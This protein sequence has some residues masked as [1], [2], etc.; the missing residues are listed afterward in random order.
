MIFEKK[1]DY[2]ITLCICT[3]NRNKGLLTL[4]NSVKKQTIFKLVP[5]SYVKTVI[6]D[7]Y[8]GSSKKIVDSNSFELNIVWNH[9]PRKGL[10]YARNKSVSLAKNTDYCFFVDDDQK[11]DSECLV[12][13]L[14]TAKQKNADLV[15]GSNPP[16]FEKEISESKVSYFTP[17]YKK[18]T[19]YPIAMCPTNCTLVLKEVLDSL[20]GPFNMCFNLTGGEDS[21]L[22]RQL[23]INNFK[24]YR[25]VRAKAYEYIPASRCRLSWIIKRS[26]RCSASLTFQDKLLKLG[27]SF[28]FVRILKA[29]IKVCLGL[30]FIVPSIFVPETNKKKLFPI[31]EIAEGLGHLFGYLNVHPEEYNKS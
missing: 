29:L 20:E 14:S 10:V 26:F 15:Y 2:L 25:S 18:P 5:K 12:E 9:E 8:D 3:Y 13:I 24:L 6:I 4:L 16:I 7:N 23:S 28:Y 19:D 17:V 1:N 31:I 30:I 21:F 27:F 11:L 22:S